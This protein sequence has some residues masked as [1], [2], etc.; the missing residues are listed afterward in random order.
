MVNGVHG[1]VRDVR[2]HVDMK[3]QGV[4]EHVIVLHLLVEEVI[5]LA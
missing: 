1:H 5:V 4:Q 2:N 3:Q